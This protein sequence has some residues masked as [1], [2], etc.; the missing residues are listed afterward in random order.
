M[1]LNRRA[2]I[3]L[4]GLS[5]AELFTK[6]SGAEESSDTRQNF[7]FGW[8]RDLPDPQDSLL[9]APSFGE[10]TKRPKLIDLS[11]K[12][13][14]P[15]DQMRLGSCTANAIAAAVQYARRVHDKPV[16]FTPSRL[17]IY[18]EARK[19]IGNIYVDSGSRIRDGIKSVASI[20][21]PPEDVWPYDGIPG[22]P[23][24]HVFPTGARSTLEPPKAVLDAAQKYKA[25]SYAPLK[26][27]LVT[28]ESCLASGYPFIF[29]FSVF[30]NFH[31]DT[32]LLKTPTSDD[33]ATN[34]GHAVLA[35]GYNQEKRTFK[36]RNSWGASSNKNGYFDMDYDYVL[37]SGFSSDFWVLYQTLGF[38]D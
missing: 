36:I 15:Y 3:I 24:T 19:I 29:G 10:P 1:D 11:P 7:G 18:Y 13:P 25:I 4:G 21:V 5:I 20:G 16:D 14:K 26:Q 12:F 37:S 6:Q 35:V 30:S 33:K 31:Y 27:D 38:I 17:F 22:D 23:T 8:I 2:A 9:Q 34:S 32:K 28:L